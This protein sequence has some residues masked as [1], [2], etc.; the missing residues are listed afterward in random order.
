MLG[1]EENLETTT[2]S[3]VLG[4]L[5]TVVMNITF[6]ANVGREGIIPFYSLQSPCE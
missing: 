2:Y 6:K 4:L 3:S 5:S 1:P